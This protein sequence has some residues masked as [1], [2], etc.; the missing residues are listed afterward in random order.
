VGA[1]QRGLLERA[2]GSGSAR[3]TYL[4]AALARLRSLQE[5]ARLG[6]PALDAA[7]LATLD[8]RLRHAEA[9][10]CA[11]ARLPSRMLHIARELGS[12]RYHR[13]SNGLRSAASD[14]VQGIQ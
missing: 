10:A 6:R 8:Q 12:G 7:Q 13:F 5:Q 2:V 14:V 9:R 1:R 4:A 11:P 3:R